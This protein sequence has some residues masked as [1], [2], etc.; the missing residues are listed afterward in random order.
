MPVTHDVLG[1]I[2]WRNARWVSVEAAVVVLHKVGGE[3]VFNFTYL[4]N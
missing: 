2:V 4:I 3:D 1:T